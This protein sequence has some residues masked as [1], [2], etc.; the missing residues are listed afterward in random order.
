MLQ[1]KL[2]DHVKKGDTL[3]DVYAERD[4]R[5]ESALKLAANIQPIGLS[6]Q[7]EDR[8]LVSRIPAPVVHRKAFTLER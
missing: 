4:T 3:F 2:G 1:A 7:P 6:R 5:L 8:M